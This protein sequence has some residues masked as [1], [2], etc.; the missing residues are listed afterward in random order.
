MLA[1]SWSSRV[2]FDDACFALVATGGLALS[3][4]V[5]SGA[6]RVVATAMAM[7]GGVIWTTIDAQRT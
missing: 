3:H 7:L 4:L 6:S 2:S 5:D 1:L